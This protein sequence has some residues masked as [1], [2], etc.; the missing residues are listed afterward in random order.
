MKADHDS[1]K[2]PATRGGAEALKGDLSGGA[3]GVDDA[4]SL[5]P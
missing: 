4:Q 1:P 3:G 2:H 5:A